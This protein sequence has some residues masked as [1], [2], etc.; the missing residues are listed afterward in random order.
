L[1]FFNAF[2]Q[3]IWYPKMAKTFSTI[4]DRRARGTYDQ[5]LE[6]RDYAAAAVSSN[7]TSTGIAFASRKIEGFKVCISHAAYTSYS[8]GSAEWTITIGVCATVGGSYVTVGTL[9]PA[10][11]AG[12]AAETEI[13]LGGDEVSDRLSTAEFIQIVATK[14]GSP[15]NL[16][17]GAWIV[18]S[19]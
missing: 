16:T 9:L 11:F 2:K 19:F 15:G 6:L 1:I 7:T 4:A 14:T 10:T 3:L 8:A 12:A 18:P 5:A 17:Y 13:V